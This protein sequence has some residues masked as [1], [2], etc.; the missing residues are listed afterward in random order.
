MEQHSA[1]T[2]G[3]LEKVVQAS[4]TQPSTTEPQSCPLCSLT[5]SSTSLY[6]KHI[7]R[8]LRELSLFALP[9]DPNDERAEGDK[10]RD[11]S[12][13]KSLGIVQ[14]NPQGDEISDS[15]D[16]L[17]SDE[18]EQVWEVELEER[19]KLLE[20]GFDAVP[21][22]ESHDQLEIERLWEEYNRP[23]AIAH[24]EEVERTLSEREEEASNECQRTDDMEKDKDT[25]P[26]ARWTKISRRLV[27]PE[28]LTEAKEPHEERPGFV[29]V[30]RVLKRQ[31]IQRLADRTSAIRGE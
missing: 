1:E 19:K 16:D 25:P 12:E 15:T 29:I 8:H 22:E 3:K 13:Y 17:E 24:E 21:S 28:A 14:V 31:E 27:N 23:E 20:A 7:G 26:D 30:T 2:A 18:G 9:V 10:S 4:E 11:D 6:A 5:F